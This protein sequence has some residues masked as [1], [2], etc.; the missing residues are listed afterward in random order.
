MESAVSC[1][2]KLN[3]AAKL[4]RGGFLALDWMSQNSDAL[5]WT[6]NSIKNQSKTFYHHLQSTLQSMANKR[7][8]V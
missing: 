6:V 4:R 7:N 1:H 2:P 8:Q 5:R 3:L